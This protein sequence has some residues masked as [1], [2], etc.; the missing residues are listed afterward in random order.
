MV[1]RGAA[2]LLVSCGIS[3]REVGIGARDAG[4]A[5]SSVVVCHKPQAGGQVVASRLAPGDTV[6]LLGFDEPSCDEVV[7]MIESQLTARLSAAA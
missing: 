1:R 4:L 6:L 2:E 5:L 3:G 7:G